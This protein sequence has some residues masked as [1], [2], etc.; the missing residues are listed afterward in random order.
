VDKLGFVR[1]IE[2]VFAAIIALSVFAFI[3]SYNIVQVQSFMRSPATE[4]NDFLDFIDNGEL[5]S[6]V[7]D[8]DYLRLDSIFNYLF[9][10]TINY[11]FE[12]VYYDKL[13]ATSS[14][15]LT[16]PNISFTYNFPRGIDK[17][18]IRVVTEN[19]ELSTNAV[20]DWYYTPIT[21]NESF[22]DAYV[23]V[24][25]TLQTSA[26]NNN[27][28]KFFVRDK[29]T[30]LSLTNWSQGATSANATIIV[31]VPEVESGEMCY[32]Y[33]AKNDS[34]IN[35][36]YASLTA[37]REVA[38][39]IFNT[40]EARTAEVVFSPDLL[41]NSDTNLYIKYSLFT[42]EPNGYTNLTNVNNLPVTIRI[43]S[44]NLKQGTSPATTNFKGSDIVKR[45][46]P[47]NNG[48]V[49]LRVYGDYI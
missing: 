15:E 36:S 10:E 25:A 7:N 2:A 8:Y 23:E 37:T 17:N 41:N 16:Q 35:I 3:Q 24:N 27:S 13:T 19:Y 31:Y 30:L 48:F 29:E 18:S 6:V 20:F 11:Y 5:T 12:P 34:Y 45:I 14:I 26:I 22:T 32:L 28:L 33:F 39:T 21:F 42:S 49:E 1:T 9:F 4:L 47:T 40:Q 44:S 46:I 38:S 43:S